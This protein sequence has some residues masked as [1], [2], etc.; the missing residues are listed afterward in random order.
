MS[1]PERRGPMGTG[2]KRLKVLAAVILT[3]IGLGVLPGVQPA[4]AFQ[5]VA[6]TGFSNVSALTTTTSV[7]F[8]TKT[9]SATNVV[10]VVVVATSASTTSVSGVTD[11]NSLAWTRAQGVTTTADDLE[12]WYASS[13]N[14][15]PSDNVTVTL[16][17]SLA[18]WTVMALAVVGSSA[19]VD[20]TAT[21][22]GPTGNPSAS[23]TVANPDDLIVAA[24]VQD[25]CTSSISAGSGT[26]DLVLAPPTFSTT[27]A[28]AVARMT[29]VKVGGYSETFGGCT[30]GSVW[31]T[32][33]VAFKSSTSNLAGTDSSACSGAC[34]PPARLTFDNTTAGVQTADDPTN[35]YQALVF[36]NGTSSFRATTMTSGD[37]YEMDFTVGSINFSMVFLASGANSGNL[38]IYY[39]QSAFTNWDQG[40]SFT[41]SSI[42]SGAQFMDSSSSIGFIPI[43]SSSITNGS[44]GA[45]VFVASKNYLG[46]LGATGSTVSGV[47]GIDFTS[48]T[49]C[50]QDRA[51]SGGICP[52]GTASAYSDRTPGTGSA[53]WTLANGAVPEFPFGVLLLALPLFFLYYVVRRR[54]MASLPAQPS[55]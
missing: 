8:A 40:K 34:P 4:Q 36:V 51:A 18:G 49:G 50:P 33:A 9:G 44:D 37:Q 23:I 25:L 27:G 52:V 45:I 21:N 15:I 20:V 14:S 47:T 11:N 38:T 41:V 7:S 3:L 35:M 54:R 5:G 17:G 29:T 22:T 55:L 48:G 42:M 2:M 53:S 10:L 46:T 31:G 39:K 6:G 43:S 26:F 12:V 1:T 13:A 19:T 28:A 24:A 32:V 30:S 16:S